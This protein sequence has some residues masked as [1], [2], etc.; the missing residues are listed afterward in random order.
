MRA[1]VLKNIAG[2]AFAKGKR[3]DI[4]IETGREQ[5]VCVAGC[6]ERPIDKRI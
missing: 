3:L 5:V 2:S 6:D 1:R 4:H